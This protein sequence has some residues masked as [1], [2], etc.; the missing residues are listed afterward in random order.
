M[1]HSG[2][3][4]VVGTMWAIADTDGRDFSEQ[5]MLS[6]DGGGDGSLCERSAK[7][8]QRAGQRVRSKKGMTLEGRVNFVH[9]EALK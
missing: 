9:Y 2:F 3:R 8:L 4:S 7:A 6:S 5:Y 1:H